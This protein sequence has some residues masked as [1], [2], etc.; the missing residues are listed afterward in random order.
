[1]ITRK[2][3][4][5]DS[6]RLHHAYYLQF[7]TEATKRLVLTHITKARIMAST[8]EHMN[9]IPLAMWDRINERVR[10]SCNTKLLRAAE[11]TTDANEGADYPPNQYPWSTN[12][13]TCIAKAVAK[14]I[15]AEG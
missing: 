15:K 5:A 8:D 7:A 10:L 3:Y 1:M 4:M 12:T 6:N 9:D 14:E 13:G 2:E 11:I